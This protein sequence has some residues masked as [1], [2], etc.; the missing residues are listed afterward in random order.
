VLRYLWHPGRPGVADG[1]EVGVISGEALPTG[2]I[3]QPLAPTPV[4]DKVVA[5]TFDDGPWPDTTQFLRVLQRAGVKATFCM[6]GRQVTAH[7]EWVRSVAGA[8]MTLCNHTQNHNEHLDKSSPAVAEAEIQGGAD[9]L[10]SVLDQAPSFYR[11]PGGALSPLVEDGANRAGE[12][13]LGWSV[14]PHDY[15]RPGTGKIIATVMAQVRPGA[16]ILLHDGGGERSQTLAALPQII[17]RLEAQGYTFTTPDAVTP[18]LVGAPAPPDHRAGPE[19]PL[20]PEG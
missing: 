7:P 8:G 6:I 10:R 9:A 16:I 17:A 5:L 3:T 11:P 18:T 20:G 19:T 15:K 13:V 12:Q 4:T 14:D 1:G 2:V